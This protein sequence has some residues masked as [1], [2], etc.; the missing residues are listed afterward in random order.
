[1]TVIYDE[2]AKTTAIEVITLVH[3]KGK[4]PVSTTETISPGGSAPAVAAALIRSGA[5]AISLTPFS[6]EA[7]ASLAAT[8]RVVDPPKDSSKK[9]DDKKNDL[10]DL[11]SPGGPATPDTGP[12]SDPARPDGDTTKPG[13]DTAKPAGGDTRPGGEKPDQRSKP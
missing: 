6:D 10:P 5:G 9:A 1:M 7:K 11:P 8:V 2:K 13:G 4:A 12:G 3:E